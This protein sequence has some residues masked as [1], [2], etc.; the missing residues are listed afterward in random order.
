M[1]LRVPHSSRRRPSASDA[2]PSSSYE[3]GPLRRIAPCPARKGTPP[4]SRLTEVRTL[5]DGPMGGYREAPARLMFRQA[6]AWLG[7]GQ[8]TSPCSRRERICFPIPSRREHGGVVPMS[9]GEVGRAGSIPAPTTSRQ[10]LRSRADP[11]CFVGALQPARRSQGTT[12]SL[13]LED[14]CESSSCPK[15]TA[16]SEPSTSRRMRRSA[17]YAAST[18]SCSAPC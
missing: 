12:L 1:L 9:V 11:R 3:W 16:S 18:A 15:A 17:S 7:R 6:F 5:G 8:Q 4:S 10:L 2:V 13:L 14:T